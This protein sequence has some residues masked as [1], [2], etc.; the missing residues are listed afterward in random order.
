VSGAPRDYIVREL[1]MQLAQLKFPS[2]P[3]LLG[4]VRSVVS[5]VSGQFGFSA[6]DVGR[7]VLAVDEACANVIKHVYDGDPTLPVVISLHSNKPDRLEIR[8]RDFGKK[9]DLE[10][11]R[12]RSLA[13]VRPGGLGV[14]FI[15]SI[16]DI[17]EYDLSPPEGT[18]LRMVKVKHAG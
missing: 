12:P 3:R 16:M 10:K 6:E 1:S 13:D 4:V 15:R 14:H 2:D 11:I 8:L 9:P 18:E 17:V 7:I 5:H